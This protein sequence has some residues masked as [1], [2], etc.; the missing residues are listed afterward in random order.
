MLSA[1]IYLFIFITSMDI[2]RI[3]YFL[4]N[5]RHPYLLSQYYAFFACY[6][7]IYDDK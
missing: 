6:I 5:F 3:T 7:Y 1:Y 2:G 4:D